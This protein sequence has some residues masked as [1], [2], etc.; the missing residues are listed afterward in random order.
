MIPLIT[1]QRSRDILRPHVPKLLRSLRDAFRDWTDTDPQVQAAMEASGRAMFLNKLFYLH[2]GLH[3]AGD[4]VEFRLD[5]QQRYMIFGEEVVLRAKLLD[6]RLEA[7]NYRTRHARQW[8]RQ[9]QLPGMAPVARLHFGYRPDVTGSLIKDVFITLPNGD[10]A[11]INH[12]AWQLYGQPIEPFFQRNLF[13][14]EVFRYE[15][16]ADAM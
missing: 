16:F 12:W 6:R 4:N 15:D 5:Q 8:V 3:L 11:T 7:R 13:A 10:A 1:L 2:A 9:Y 14:D